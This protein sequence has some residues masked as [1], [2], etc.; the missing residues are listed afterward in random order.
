MI[1]LHYDFNPTI[2]FNRF[3]I[4]LSVTASSI[5]NVFKNGR[6]TVLFQTC[7]CPKNISQNK[8]SNGSGKWNMLTLFW[9]KY[10]NCLKRCN[11]VRTT[12]NIAEGRKTGE[13]GI[14]GWIITNQKAVYDINCSEN[15]E[16]HLRRNETSTRVVPT[17][18]LQQYMGVC[19]MST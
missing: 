1:L 16:F 15:D 11:I 13:I 2:S 14:I 19:I 17:N 6:T 3:G 18:Y 7:L 9:I 4:A 10:G 12:L 8:T 5:S